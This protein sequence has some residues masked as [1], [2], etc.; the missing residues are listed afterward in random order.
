M[1]S[2]IY[3]LTFGSGKRYIR[4]SSDVYTARSDHIK[5]LMS[6]SATSRLQREYELFGVLPSH[7]VLAFIHPNHLDI[8]EAAFIKILRPELS[9]LELDINE[10]DAQLLLSNLELLKLS[11]ADHLRNITE[12]KHDLKNCKLRE[13]DLKKLE[14]HVE[15]DERL[16]DASIE[17]VDDLRKTIADLTA[18]NCELIKKLKT[19]WY[20]KLF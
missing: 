9:P 20:K 14:E 1:N 5:L 16:A 11:T 17:C 19:P 13:I 12:I 2:G 7:E 6:N 8:T 10:E 15:R 4:R 18:K 3:Q